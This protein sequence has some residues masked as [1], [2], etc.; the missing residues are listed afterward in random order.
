MLKGGVAD[1]E[2][3]NPN[4]YLVKDRQRFELLSYEW[5]LPC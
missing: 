5:C 1:K 4:R 3:I 2:C